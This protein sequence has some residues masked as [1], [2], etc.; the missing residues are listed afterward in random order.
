MSKFNDADVASA[1]FVPEVENEPESLIRLQRTVTAMATYKNTAVIGRRFS[2]SL[3]SQKPWQ[4]SW[5]TEWAEYAQ[6]PALMALPQ[7]HRDY[8]YS[9]RAFT[10]RAFARCESPL[11]ELFLMAVVG[12]DPEVDFLRIE[13]AESTTPVGLWI[14]SGIH[15]FQQATIGDY[16]VDFV[17]DPPGPEGRPHVVE[18]DGHAYHSSREALQRDK[19]RDRTLQERGYSVLR[20]TYEDVWKDPDRAALEVRKTVLS[21]MKS[22]GRAEDQCAQESP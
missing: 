15:V 8:L 9:V 1:L 5:A 19:A 11:E 7:S 22:T 4:P 3:G 14:I 12:V 10:K 20:F 18:I 17:F 13:Q 2:H 16:R 6:Q 21:S